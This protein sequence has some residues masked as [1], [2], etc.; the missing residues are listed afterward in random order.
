MPATNLTVG[1]AGAG[2]MG[3]LLA[4]QLQQRGYR[5]TL[6]D[7]A[8]LNQESAAAFVAAGMLAPYAEL[9]TADTGIFNM[10]M[11]SLDLW[12]DLIK[13]L[14]SKPLWHQGGSL[15]LAHP[16]D[17]SY[18]QRF[19]Q[20]LEAHDIEPGKVHHL[21][22]SAL[23]NHNS[24]LA[25][26]FNQAIYLPQESWIYTHELLK[27]L[28]QRIVAAGV[29]WHHQTRVE[30]VSS[31]CI[32]STMGN[33]VFDWAVDCRG[34]GAKPQMP[35]L[36]GVRGEVLEVH[37]PEVDITQM[38]RLMHPHY[39]LYLV[40]RANHHYLLGATQIESEDTSNIS[41]RSA[42]ELLSA[43][44]S[45]HP[46]FAEA[47]IVGTAT[48][49]RPALADNLPAI[50]SRQGLLKING[51]YRHGYLLAPTLAEEAIKCIEANDDLIFPN[52][53]HPID[54]CKGPSQAKPRADKLGPNKEYP[55]SSC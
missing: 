18:L 52:I 51:L 53:H 12:P 7:Q 39:R 29:T 47:R 48:G 4:W 33:H 13:D 5:V 15:V 26:H 22:Q 17:T 8:A 16:Q 38:V 14:T 9:E 54:L 55:C 27:I 11:H 31:G 42:L 30:N 28:Q 35:Q 2:L 6:F 50:Y 23:F 25:E 21:N 32:T 24:G 45:L 1:I 49:C 40:P 44:Y 3:R 43:L 19:L 34:L 20:Q 41:V 10:G 36:R 46:G 37:A